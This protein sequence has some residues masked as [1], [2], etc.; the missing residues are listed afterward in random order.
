MKACRT[1][2]HRA[3]ALAGMAVGLVLLAGCGYSD[4]ASDPS[5]ADSAQ[6]DTAKEVCHN[7]VKL[8]LQSPATAD[9]SDERVHHTG[10][11]I[12]VVGHVDS[13][14]GFGALLRSTFSCETVVDVGEGTVTVHG[15]PL[16]IEGS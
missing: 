7:A 15:T 5:Y 14:N 8:Q 1:A 16:V 11:D 2:D 3:S 10:D 12:A 13:E 9:F 4:P 6:K